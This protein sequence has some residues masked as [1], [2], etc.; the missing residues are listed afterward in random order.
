LYRW[1]GRKVADRLY[2]ALR[3]R[4]RAELDGLATDVDASRPNLRQSVHSRPRRTDA[5]GRPNVDPLS[6]LLNETA[7]LRWDVK[8]LA[9]AIA[10]DQLANRVSEASHGMAGPKSVGLNSRLCRQTDMEAPWLLHWCD[11]LRI[12]PRY[13]RKIW[14]L[15]FVLQALW[16]AGMLAPARRGLGFAVGAEPIPAFL[17]GQGAEILASDL[18]SGDE[19]ASAWQSSGQ[20]SSNLDALFRGEFVSHDAFLELCSFR[21]ID[22]NEVPRDLDGTFDFCWSMCSVEHVG[23]IELGL[24]F[25]EN[26]VRCLKPGG[27]AVHTAEFNLDSGE[28]TIDNWP[29]VLFKRRHIDALANRLGAL[30]HELV[31]VDYDAGSDVLDGFVDVPPYSIAPDALLRYPDVPH[32]RLSVDQFPAT[33]IGLIVRAGGTRQ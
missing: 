28:E 19:R 25:I 22:M 8:V 7:A 9:A 17:V 30:G 1:L 16:E 23:S 27:V 4:L 14:E 12:V 33:S 3:N 32:L 24:R 5:D 2:T 26:S 20:H 11:Q 15:A 6:H 29:T 13:H 10:K 31:T 21:P 18:A